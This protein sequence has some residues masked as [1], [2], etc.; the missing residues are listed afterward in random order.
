MGE[1]CNWWSHRS[2]S[3]SSLN[4]FS[5]RNR[6]FNISEID[7][8][9]WYQQWSRFSR[10]QGGSYTNNM[11]WHTLSAHENRT[12]YNYLSCKNPCTVT[13]MSY[14]EIPW[15]D[16]IIGG[17]SHNAIYE[18]C[19]KF[20]NTTSENTVVSE[21]T[22]SK[23]YQ[24]HSAQA[25]RALPTHPMPLRNI[26]RKL[27]KIFSVPIRPRLVITRRGWSSKPYARSKI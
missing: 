26:T 19:H 22:L 12:Y 17:Y 20:Y 25:H 16:S 9:H 10:N 23:R 7:V 1:A 13:H 14:N 15:R 6:A 21:R 11:K 2:A 24:L 18:R 8:L 5:H 4:E 3:Y 27:Y